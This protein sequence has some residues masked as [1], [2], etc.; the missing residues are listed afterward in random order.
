[1]S[2]IAK[3]PVLLPEKVEILIDTDSVTVKGVNGQLKQKIHSS[4][5]VTKSEENGGQLVFEPKQESSSAWAQAGTMRALT[6]NMV[7]GVSVGFQITLE[8]VGVGYRAQLKGEEISLAL[9]FSHPVSYAL[10][11]GLKADLPNNTTII[12]KAADKQLVG[13]VAAEIRSLRP[14]EPYKG[15]GIKYS[16]EVIVRKET[17][18]K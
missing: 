8:L 2:R 12:L 17:K 5:K 13:Q 18:K 14:P 16:G 4:V 11:K 9:G 15:K 10:P 6:S 3:A 7:H 1:M